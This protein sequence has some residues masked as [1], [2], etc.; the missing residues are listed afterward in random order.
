M[1]DQIRSGKGKRFVTFALCGLVALGALVVQWRI[2]SQL[3]RENLALRSAQQLGI[4]DLQPATA[5]SEPPSAESVLAALSDDHERLQKDRTELL[6]LRNEVRQLRERVAQPQTSSNGAGQPPVAAS[7]H[8]PVA[9]SNPNPI[10][11]TELSSEWRGQEQFATNKLTQALNRFTNAN[12]HIERFH[13][14]GDVAK[15]NFAFGNTEDAQ[16]AATELLA[17]A[18]KYKGAHW[19]DGCGQAIHDGNLVLGRLALEQ[20][21]IDD[22]KRYLL[23]AG[24]STGSPVLGSFGPNMSLARDLLEKGEGETVLQYFERCGKFWKIETLKQW[25]DEVIAGRMPNFGANLIY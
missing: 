3:R 23:E 20:G 12:H 22:A 16:S 19:S 6:R 5:V 18:E 25:T 14:L 4:E 13:A 8:N 1:N 11:R 10:P 21:A 17:L 15:M 2:N 9:Q 24:T 7:A